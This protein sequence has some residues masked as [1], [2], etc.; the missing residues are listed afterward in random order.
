MKKLLVIVAILLVAVL[1]V[2]TRPEK[3]AHKE[4]M[5]KA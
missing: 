1:M 5:R 2:M 4:A 3:D